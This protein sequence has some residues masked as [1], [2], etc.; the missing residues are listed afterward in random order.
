MLGSSTVVNISRT[1]LRACLGIFLFVSAPLIVNAAFCCNCHPDGNASKNVCLTDPA[2]GCV[3]NEIIAKNN[4]PALKGYTCDPEPLLASS[5]CLPVS[6]GNASAKCQEGPTDA[7]AY[8]PSDS[9]PKPETFKP[10]PLTPNIPIPELA[11]ATEIPVKDNQA[12]IP[13]IAQ[14]ISAAYK[15]LISITVITAAVVMIYGGFLYI[16][17]STTGNVAK[18]KKYIVNAVIGL[19][20]TFSSF[21]ILQLINPAT[22]VLAPID[23]PLVKKL[24]EVSASQIQQVTGKLPPPSGEMLKRAQDAATALAGPKFGCFVNSSMIFESGGRSNVIG[25]DENAQDVT[26]K[27]GA[28]QTFLQSGKKYSG[29]KFEPVPCPDKTCQSNKILNDDVSTFNLTA[30][31]DYGLDWKYS[32]GIGAGQSTIFPANKP[33]SGKTQLGRGFFVD[34]Q[35]YTIQDLFDADKQIDAMVRHYKSCWLKTGDGANP[36][37]G[38]IC[39]GGSSLTP[40][41]KIIVDRV[42]AYKRCTGS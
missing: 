28:R 1:C 34:G 32:H 42:N 24:E 7:T 4:N 26:Y 12:L 27:V 40:E 14:Y 11:Y 21:T 19:I 20:I 9:A 39:Y 31:P 2:F 10:I 3:G 18:G 29:E 30:P 37:A 33:C 36:A 35:C 17:G 22:V 6:S 13:Y 16:I 5:S 8:K 23:L 38:Y 25:H 41:S 15:Y